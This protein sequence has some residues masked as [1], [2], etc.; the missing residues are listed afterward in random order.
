M[1]EEMD[2]K[3]EDQDKTNAY[4][5]RMQQCCVVVVWCTKQMTKW[6][7]TLQLHEFHQLGKKNVLLVLHEEKHII[8][9]QTHCCNNK[10]KFIK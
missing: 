1:L 3:S 9:G 5:Y 10:M 6:N 4:K 8:T 2:K 7:N